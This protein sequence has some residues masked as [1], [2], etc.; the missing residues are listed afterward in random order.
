MKK[1]ILIL[2]AISL[3]VIG[4]V[5]TALASRFFNCPD[6]GDFPDSSDV[7]YFFRC[8]DGKATRTKCP[9]VTVF[10]PETRK[11]KTAS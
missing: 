9:G 1:R 3:F 6:D 5:S 7:H 10:D 11:C 4:L 8:K 2:S